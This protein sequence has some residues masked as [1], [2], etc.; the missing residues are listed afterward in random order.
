MGEK[1]KSKSKKTH[2]QKSHSKITTSIKTNGVQT[3]RLGHIFDVY[4]PTTCN[5][6]E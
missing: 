2:T 4:G 3:D 1:Y 5:E 6:K